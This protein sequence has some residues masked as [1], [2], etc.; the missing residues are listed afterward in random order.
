MGGDVERRS[1]TRARIVL[2][3]RND[4]S[5]WLF[6][7]RMLIR[8]SYNERK[9]YRGKASVGNRQP[10]AKRGRLLSVDELAVRRRRWGCLS[11]SLF[12]S[13]GEGDL[14]L[15]RSKEAV[16]FLF[17]FGKRSVLSPFA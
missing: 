15:D 11:P 12:L 8:D 17:L 14:M 3:S 9:S 6:D 1:D 4:V 16:R 7:C 2:R 13:A 5:E 10:G